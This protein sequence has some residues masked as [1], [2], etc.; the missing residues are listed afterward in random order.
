MFRGAGGLD[1]ELLQSVVSLRCEVII[2]ER[3]VEELLGDALHEHLGFGDVFE[4][5]SRH[6]KDLPRLAVRW[7][8]VLAIQDVERVAVALFA[9]DQ[10]E[11]RAIGHGCSPTSTIGAADGLELAPVVADGVVVELVPVA[12]GED[13]DDR[14]VVGLLEIGL[15]GVS[16]LSGVRGCVRSLAPRLLCGSVRTRRRTLL[17]GLPKKLWEQA[18]LVATLT[19][20]WLR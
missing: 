19:L 16:V 8:R 17:Q 6:L 2:F 15:D 1:A 5:A 20:R 18:P 13:G 14:V 9:V 10:A 7:R 3:A 12:V 11:L 4:Q